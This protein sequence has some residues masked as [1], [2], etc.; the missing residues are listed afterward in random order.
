MDY[1]AFKNLVRRVRSQLVNAW[2][3]PGPCDSRLAATWQVAVAHLRPLQAPA[4]RQAGTYRVH[5]GSRHQHLMFGRVREQPHRQ[6]QLVESVAQARRARRPGRARRTEPA[7]LPLARRVPGAARLVSVLGAIAW[8]LLTRWFARSSAAPRLAADEGV[9]HSGRRRRLAPPQGR[10]LRTL[11][12]L[13][14]AWRRCQAVGPGARLALL[15]ACGAA[16]LRAWTR[17][18]LPL[19]LLDGAVR[20][21]A[22]CLDLSGSAHACE[23]L[24]DAARAAPAGP[25]AATYGASHGT[26]HAAKD[27]A[28]CLKPSGYADPHEERPSGVL[29]GAL[30]GAGAWADRLDLEILHPGSSLDGAA[31]AADRMEPLAALT[32][33]EY[34]GTAHPPTGSA[35][36]A[37]AADTLQ[38]LSGAPPA[39]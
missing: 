8:A 10:T 22:A 34:A 26:A 3:Q 14:C 5:S 4:L 16:R 25:G 30:A 13:Q 6:P 19:D 9:A 29:R 12:E 37:F 39:A 32:E 27:P 15:R 35:D 28:G 20:A 38:A 17:A 7:W 24:P 2:L 33:R 21:L 18:E 1:E 36:A 23:D 31:A 11:A